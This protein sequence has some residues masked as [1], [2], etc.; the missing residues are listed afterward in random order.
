MSDTASSPDLAEGKAGKRMGWSC[1]LILLL[2]VLASRPGPSLL[3]CAFYFI[4]GVLH[5]AMAWVFV[6]AVFFF[7]AAV[8]LVMIVRL[9][10][11]WSRARLLRRLVWIGIIVLSATAMCF[12]RAPWIPLA[13]HT[14]VREVLPEDRAYLYGFRVKV[15]CCIDVPAIRT[16]ARDNRGLYITK[17]SDAF[18]A[19]R[20]PDSVK[21]L[22]PSSTYVLPADS[23][24]VFEGMMIWLRENWV[25]V[26]CQEDDHVPDFDTEALPVAPGVWLTLPRPGGPRAA[27]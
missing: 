5:V 21:W 9:V 17:M 26:V 11:R 6:F 14:Y 4:A 1:E 25:L 2:L 23:T 3:L 24:A 19:G 18:A 7:P 10:I 16:W 20:V 13:L 27:P 22:E 12:K 8:V 15:R